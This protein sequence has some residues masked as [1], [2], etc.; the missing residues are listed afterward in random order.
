FDY[1]RTQYPDLWAKNQQQIATFLFDLRHWENNPEAF[2]RSA[3]L[4]AQINDHYFGM[5]RSL[6]SS[7]MQ[8]GPVYITWEL[9]VGLVEDPELSKSLSREYQ[10]VP[11]GLIFELSSDRSFQIP[12]NPKL[13]LRGLNDNSFKF[14]PDDVVSLK[15]F[16]VYANM[17]TNRGRY[18]AAYGRYNDAVAAYQQ[19]LKLAPNFKPA[20][21]GLTQAVEAL[22]ASREGSGKR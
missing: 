3:E 20:L 16:P 22:R 8:S 1:L 6:V 13:G 14:E 19:A 2:N 4:T 18:L 9:V 10:F 11:Q 15:V 7:N 21:D 5:I 17:L 12:L